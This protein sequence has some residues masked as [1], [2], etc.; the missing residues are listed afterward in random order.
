MLKF[1]SPIRLNIYQTK[2]MDFNR[3]WIHFSRVIMFNHHLATHNTPASVPQHG[4]VTTVTSSHPQT[5]DQ[6]LQDTFARADSTNQCLTK[7]NNSSPVSSAS[8]SNF[9]NGSRLSSDNSS[10]HSNNSNSEKSGVNFTAV[11]PVLTPAPQKKT[12]SVVKGVLIDRPGNLEAELLE[13]EN[14]EENGPEV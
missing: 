10:F 7:A 11:Q 5:D 3:L 14:E 8:S 6:K 13:A 12:V 2:A 1:K 4:F 9:S